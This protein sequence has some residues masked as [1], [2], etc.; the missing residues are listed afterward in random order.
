VLLQ[1]YILLSRDVMRGSVYI[2]FVMMGL[3]LF[4]LQFQYKKNLVVML[5]SL[6]LLM[7]TWARMEAAL[8]VISAWGFM[9]FVKQEHKWRRLFYFAAPYLFILGL[10]FGLF[11]FLQVDVWS[12]LRIEQRIEHLLPKFEGVYEGLKL[13]SQQP[14][15]GFQIAFFKNVRNLIW[16]LAL[17]T[18]FSHLTETLYFI[19][20]V[21]L[22]VGIVVSFKK[23]GKDMRLLYLGVTSLIAL[24]VLYFQIIFT[25][26][27]TS[28]FA[29]LFILP[30]FVFMAAGVDKIYNGLQQRLQRK[31][32]H[33]GIVMAVVIMALMLPKTLRANYVKEKQIINEIGQFIASKEQYQR[34]VKIAGALK[35]LRFV[36]FF[37][38]LEYEGAPCY[39]WQY[40]LPGGYPADPLFFRENGFHYYLWDEKGGGPQGLDW[41]EKDPQHIFSKV[42]EWKSER[43]G[44]LILYEIRR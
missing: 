3:Y 40:L 38:N 27:M 1:P 9:L 22:V 14:L 24:M 12:L 25:W 21:V 17:G 7:A 29:L 4:V 8:L 37:A 28:R 31:S 2:F 36:H 11:W 19:F 43:W 6:S 10:A 32:F 26:S 13:L 44:R 33:A 30:A 34:P 18:L 42:R 15:D 23:M 5:S 20:P 41:I 35:R 16:W 39:D